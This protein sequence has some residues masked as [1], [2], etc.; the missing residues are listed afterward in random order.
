M[1]SEEHTRYFLRY[2]NYLCAVQ[3]V[4]IQFDGNFKLSN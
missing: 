4:Y 3:M 2:N 1:T